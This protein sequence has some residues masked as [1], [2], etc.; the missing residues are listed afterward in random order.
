MSDESEVTQD[1]P[2]GETVETPANIEAPATG[3]EQTPEQPETPESEPERP[4]QEPWF[5]KRINTVTREKYEAERR[6]EAAERTLAELRAGKP[7]QVDAPP[8]PADVDRQIN[9][10]AQEIV[11]KNQFDD[12]CNEAYS[13]GKAEFSDFDATL[14][15]FRLLGEASQPLIEAVIQL[16][17]AHKVLYALGQD[18]DEAERISSLPPVPMAVALAKLSMSQPKAKPVSNAPPPIRP[19]DGAPKGQID[20]DDMS[21][22]EWVKWREAEL[23]SS[24]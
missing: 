15:N 11:R 1:L 14:G 8:A 5:Q 4:K 13:S 16:P 20:P 24:A 19:I 18:M 6:A 10:R 9:E 21:T 22:D 17:D 7:D 23:K 3:T 2:E 12:R